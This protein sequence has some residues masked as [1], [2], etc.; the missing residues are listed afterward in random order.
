MSIAPK[1]G[2]GTMAAS[3]A[4]VAWK[5]IL[6]AL[7][8]YDGETVVRLMRQTFDHSKP[9]WNACRVRMDGWF[10]AW[11]RDRGFGFDPNIPDEDFS[12]EALVSFVSRICP[13]AFYLKASTIPRLL[14]ELRMLPTGTT[15]GAVPPSQVRGLVSNAVTGKMFEDESKGRPE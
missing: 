13:D 10:E 2:R 11:F 8:A 3:P 15:S 5:P 9:V 14:T 6:A 7:N 12:R 4:D 1:D